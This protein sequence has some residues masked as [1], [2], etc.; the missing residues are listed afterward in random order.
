MAKLGKLRITLTAKLLMLFLTVLIV[1]IVIF[2][3]IAYKEASAGM[4]QGVYNQIDAKAADVVNQIQAI[5][6][7]QFQMLHAL[8]EV[9]ILKDEKVSLADKQ[10]QLVSAAKAAGA[11]CENIAFYDAQGNAITADG[12]LMNFAARAYSRDL[13]LS[14]RI[15]VR[16]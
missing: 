4:K 12:R 10:K 16:F 15:I 2:G 1:S 6:D 14:V 8:A 11:N 9:S 5:N 3:E 7:R 13:I